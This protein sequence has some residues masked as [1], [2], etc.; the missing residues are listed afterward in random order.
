M[1]ISQ[2]DPVVLV[3]EDQGLLRMT[4]VSI[5][6]DSGFEAVEAK[7]AD[8][9][10]TMLRHYPDILVVFTDIDLNAEKDGFW[11][12]EQIKIGW[13]KIDVIV[14]S[15]YPRPKNYNLDNV[16]AYYEKPYSEKDLINQIQKAVFGSRRGHSIAE[17]VSY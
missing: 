11:L 13:P 5:M 4:A 8:E 1:S 10:L 14:T 15:A 16:I 7:N 9:A 12:A 6:E 2:F 3:V 17:F